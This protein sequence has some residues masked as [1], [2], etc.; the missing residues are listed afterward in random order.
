VDGVTYSLQNWK[1][2]HVLCLWNFAWLFYCDANK[3]SHVCDLS[4]DVYLLQ[5]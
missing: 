1:K 5:T 3:K 4:N 2:V